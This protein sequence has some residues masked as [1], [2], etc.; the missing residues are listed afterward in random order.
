MTRVSRISGT[1]ANHVWFALICLGSLVL[2]RAPL[3]ALA[4]LAL[5]DE[6]YSYIAFVPFISATLIY[7]E[8]SQIFRLAPSSRVAGALLASIGFASSWMLRVRAAAPNQDAGLSLFAI[9]LILVWIGGFLFCYGSASWK[10]ASFPLVFLFLAAPPPPVVLETVVVWLQKGSA[11]VSQILFKL[12]GVPVL[13]EGFQFSLPGLEIEV[14]EQ[15]SGI[16]SSISMFL[17]SV[18]AGHLVL[19]S[20]W[21]KI[22][23]IL[24]TVP[25]VVAKN[26]LR[27]VVLSLLGAYVDRG[28]L[29]GGIHKSSGLLFSPLAL[30]VFA[31]LLWMLYRSERRPP[32]STDLSA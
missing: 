22:C 2:F 6:R 27:I 29:F 17:A 5:Y 30:L 24:L 23:L 4:H 12:I 28:V 1:T 32:A 16:R 10:A 25:I 20:T 8:R 14:A 7:L 9:A 11:D 26:A 18:L 21:K 31:W 15:C 3:A 19:H 13:R